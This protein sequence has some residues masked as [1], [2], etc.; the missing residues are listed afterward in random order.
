ML[1]SNDDV[2]TYTPP[3]GVTTC[4]KRPWLRLD[5]IGQLAVV[6]R[7]VDFNNLCTARDVAGLRPGR[8]AGT[9]GFPAVNFELRARLLLL[10]QRL[11][12]LRCVALDVSDEALPIALKHIGAN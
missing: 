3:C 7:A 12:R 6:I 10:H 2:E 9:F 1:M 11:V 8:F 5:R 4:F